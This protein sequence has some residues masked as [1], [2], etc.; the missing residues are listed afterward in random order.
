[1]NARSGSS[2]LLGPILYA[3]ALGAI[4]IKNTS[5][6]KYTPPTLSI[7]NSPARSTP[8]SLPMSLWWH[9]PTVAN[10]IRVNTLAPLVL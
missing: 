9:K 4:G 7:Y 6:V 3:V 5:P 2:L 1:M 10:S 8:V